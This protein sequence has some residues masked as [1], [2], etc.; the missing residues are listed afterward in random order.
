MPISSV[1][2][3]EAIVLAGALVEAISF[4]ALYRWYATS[5]AHLRQRAAAAACVVEVVPVYG[6][7][8]VTNDGRQ[9]CAGVSVSAKSTT[10]SAGV[11]DTSSMRLL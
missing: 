1:G 10:P 2:F 8:P 9:S 6:A 5:D 3:V 4:D 11:F 7:G